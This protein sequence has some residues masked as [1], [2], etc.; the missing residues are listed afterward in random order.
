MGGAVRSFR[1]GSQRFTERDRAEAELLRLVWEEGG[2][3][4]VPGAVP[5][6]NDRNV[7]C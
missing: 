1:R 7:S 2:P 3:F 4:P 5:P 6:P